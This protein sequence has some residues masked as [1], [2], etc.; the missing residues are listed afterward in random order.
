MLET[1]TISVVIPYLNSPV[2]LIDQL[3]K[4]I[5]HADKNELRKIYI[6]DGGNIS[7]TK[8]LLSENN[9]QS[10]KI[11]L[12]ENPHKFTP[13]ALNAG[14]KAALD[15]GATVVQYFG[16]HGGFS[17][18]FFTELPALFEKYNY[19][20]ILTP[21]K[22]FTESVN[23]FQK[24]VQFFSLSKLG[25]NWNKTHN[26]KKAI[27]GFGSG[28]FAA[29]KEVFEKTGLFDEKY[30]KNQDNE[31]IYRA[32]KNGF[33]VITVPEIK[34]Y[35]ETRAS[36]SKLINQN[37][38]YGMY[39]SLD[40]KIY[41]L[42]QNAPFLFYFSLIG[43]IVLGLLFKTQNLNLMSDLF[44]YTAVT[45]S[46]VYYF[47]IFVESLRFLIKEGV[48]ALHLLYL[49]PLIHIVYAAGTLSGYIRRLFGRKF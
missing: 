38:Y 13:Q 30:I 36:I 32:V 6:V 34:I 4:L 44:L 47:T 25:R 20:S 8:S 49:F 16:A 1:S 15:D 28:G 48:S 43:C 31:F 41:G 17:S 24:A 3:K 37:Y 14:T 39:V 22:G 27:E 2:P 23:G 21:S 19:A 33:R 35:Y 40:P 9:L 29:K 10:D 11:V 42:K 26:I 46:L 45:V 18:N 12:I 7:E 5:I